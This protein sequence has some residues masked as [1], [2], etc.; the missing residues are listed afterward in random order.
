MPCDSV[1]A[2]WLAARAA[3][4]SR[5]RSRAAWR[6]HDLHVAG[7]DAEL[8]GV[9]HA[10]ELGLHD[11]VDGL[12]VA[13]QDHRGAAGDLDAELHVGRLG[14]PGRRV[15]VDRGHRLDGLHRGAAHRLQVGHDA[16]GQRARGRRAGLVVED[17][18]GAAE[19][20]R[21]LAAVQ[22]HGRLDGDAP[23][24]GRSGR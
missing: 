17:R 16:A 24:T 15:G 2:A 20:D 6:A 23:G 13:G 1:A 3:S 8:A 4:P 14:P 5:P 22:P 19:R 11:R 12:E 18:P 7:A 21:A 9:G 10:G